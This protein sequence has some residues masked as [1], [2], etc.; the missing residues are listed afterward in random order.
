MNSAFLTVFRREINA[1]FS[2]AIAT[3]FIIVFVLLNSGLYMTQFFVIGFADMRPF[4]AMLP[5]VLAV[6]LPA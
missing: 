4:F 1:Y 2:A 3:I 5:F 6:F